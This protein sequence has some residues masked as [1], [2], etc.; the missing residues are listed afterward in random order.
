[1]TG[2]ERLAQVVGAL[3]SVGVAC[4]VMG[5]HAVRFYG[6]ARNTDDFD[7]HIAPAS[8]DDLAERLSRSSLYT[9]QPVNEGSS[10]R[11]GAFRRFRIG[12]L[13]DG[14]DEWL[15]CWRTNHLLPAY[16]DLLTRAERGP[17]GGREVTFLG[18]PDLIRSK[19]TERDKDWR[20]VAVLEQV[21]DSRL[22]AQVK[23]GRRPV[24][25]ALASLRSRAGFESYLG[26]GLLLDNQA[27]TQALAQ[28][29]SPITQAYLIPLVPQ[30]TTAAPVCSIEPVLLNRLQ[31]VAV[32]SPLHLS[33]VEI[34]R[35]RYITFR[36]EAD[37]GDKEAIRASLE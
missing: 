2:E 6:L 20:D 22:L 14:R 35:R 5:G 26:E 24:A 18:L 30:A 34:I 32:G 4:L 7:L 29:N 37:R 17:Y 13:P 33:L 25:E 1:V 19:E 16:D 36:K 27:V 9:G 12:S 10:W 31:S 21:L 11:P 23:V 28:T 15:E 3:E 8:W